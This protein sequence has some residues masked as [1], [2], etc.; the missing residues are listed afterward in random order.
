M[1]KANF[2]LELDFFSGLQNPVLEISEEDFAALCQMIL[3]LEKTTPHPLFDGLGFRGF[4]L[5]DSISTF[6]F[7][8]KNII[9]IEL[10][11]KVQYRKSSPEVLSK[12]ISIAKK[13]DK[14]NN[15]RIIIEKIMDEYF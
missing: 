7:I 3:R 6:L 5:S 14:E 12:L 9:K 15:Y 1:S 4:I 10:N 13:Y 2:K 8:Q 11:K